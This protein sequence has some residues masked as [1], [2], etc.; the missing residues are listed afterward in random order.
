MKESEGAQK[1]VLSGIT[2]E[3]QKKEIIM[4]TCKEQRKRRNARV[5][6]ESKKD[7]GMH[8]RGISCKGLWYALSHSGRMGDCGIRLGQGLMT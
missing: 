8:K 6:C 4:K 3:R 2:P 7:A 5:S 1:T